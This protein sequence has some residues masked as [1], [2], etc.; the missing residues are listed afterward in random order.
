MFE[1]LKTIIKPIDKPDIKNIASENYL[2]YLSASTLKEYVR[3]FYGTLVSDV[4]KQEPAIEIFK[5][6]TYGAIIKIPYYYCSDIDPIHS[7]DYCYIGQFGEL[8]ETE[9]GLRYYTIERVETKNFYGLI[10]SCIKDENV[11]K[12]YNSEFVAAHKLVLEDAKNYFKQAEQE[13]SKKTIERIELKYNEIVEDIEEIGIDT[14]FK[15]KD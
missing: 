3:K 1:K 12:Q 10:T 14:Y 13:R 11:I 15:M 5:D 9:N 7:K 4:Y 2:S 6:K 8:Y